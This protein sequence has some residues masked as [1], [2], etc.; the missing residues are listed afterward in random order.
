MIFHLPPGTEKCPAGLKGT[1][2]PSR[3]ETFR[4]AL[5]CGSYTR[6]PLACTEFT[7]FEGFLENVPQSR[8]P[9]LACYIWQAPGAV[10]S[11]SRVRHTVPYC[12][13]AWIQGQWLELRQRS[14]GPGMR[15]GVPAVRGWAGNAHTKR[16]NN[17]QLCFPRPTHAC[18]AATALHL[19]SPG[20]ALLLSSGIGAIMWTASPHF[21]PCSWGA[22]CSERWIF[23]IMDSSLLQCKIFK[24]YC[25]SESQVLRFS[26]ISGS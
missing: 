24:N 23:Q 14:R 18:A 2:E 4:W 13:L 21:V 16:L 12:P 17:Q 6:G 7:Q 22:R 5:A 19:P 11:A 25:F 9:R 15:R 3:S 1:L 20:R 10:G 26:L 8:V